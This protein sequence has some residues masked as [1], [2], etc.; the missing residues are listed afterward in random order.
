MP[1][2]YIGFIIFIYT[3]AIIF[4]SIS[5]GADL[6]ANANI[7]DPVQGT[8]FYGIQQYETD[9]ITIT[10]PS[11]SPTFFASFFSILSLDFP[12]FSSGPWIVLRWVIL[13][14]IVGIVVFGMIQL[15]SGIMQRQV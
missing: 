8:Q 9:F 2:K 13:A 1:T 14:P 6:F 7:T 10:N 11:F 5:A 15:F 12:I 4:G 3:T